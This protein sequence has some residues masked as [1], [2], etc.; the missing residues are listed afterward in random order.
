MVLTVLCIIRFGIFSESRFL[1]LFDDDYCQYTLDV[2]R[3]NAEYYTAP[4]GI[5]LLIMGALFVCCLIL[6]ITIFRLRH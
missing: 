1:S 4:T 2:I 3:T 6:I 5:D